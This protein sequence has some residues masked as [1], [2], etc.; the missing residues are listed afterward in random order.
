MESNE[1]HTYYPT[2]ESNEVAHYS[3]YGIQV[4]DMCSE[5]SYF[6]VYDFRQGDK[7]KFV[8]IRRPTIV[9]YKDDNIT[10]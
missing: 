9:T 1:V 10:F 6:V 4:S 2:M 3:D 5:L 7:T 8:P